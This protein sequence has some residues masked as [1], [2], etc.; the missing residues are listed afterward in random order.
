VADRDDAKELVV[1]EGKVEFQHVK[2]AYDVRNPTI[3]GVSLQAEGGQTIAFVGET[4]GGK[5]TILKLLFRFYDVTGGS[6]MIDG[7]DLRS[8]TQSSLREALGLV[9]QD[10][11][12]F[13][14]TIRQ[15]IRYARLE[16]TDQE[17]EDAC[18]AAAIHDDIEGFPDKYNSKVGERGVRLSG[19]QLQRIAIARVLLKNPKIVL[20]DEA[21][22]AIDSAVEEQIQLAFRRLSKGRT[23][24]VIAHRLSTTADADQILVIDKGEI[25]ERGTHQV[26][27]DVGGKYSTLWSKQTAGHLSAPTGKAPAE[28]TDDGS[29]PLIDI[30]PPEEDFGTVTKESDNSDKTVGKRR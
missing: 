21:T 9:P 11:A 14:Q 1:K 7:Q 27:L 13:N 16:A 29:T 22:S 2:F 23:T 30:I 28:A 3:K 5:S 18:R 26:L 8:V 4:G 17:I 25:I 19:G 20:L 6:I 10:P 12:L 15:N 24:F